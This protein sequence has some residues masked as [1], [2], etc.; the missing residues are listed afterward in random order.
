[1]KNNKLRYTVQAAVIA[2]AYAVLTMAI[3]PLGIA[4]G[5]IQFRL[6]EALTILPVL[7]HAAIPGLTIG[8]FVANLTSNSGPL[9][10]VFGTFASLIAAVLT[11]LTRNIQYKGVPWLSSLFPVIVNAVVISWMLTFF[12]LEGEASLNVF[13]FN[14]ATIGLGQMV[15]CVG[16]GLP[17][18]AALK[19]KNLGFRREEN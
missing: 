4:D 5:A 12:V 7:T 15:C 14:A 2:A 11:Y 1:M 10:L 13:L 6:S 3:R 16:G 19:N 9:D 8:C 18:H 17:L